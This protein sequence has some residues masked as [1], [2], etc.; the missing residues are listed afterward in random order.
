MCNKF[1]KIINYSNSLLNIRSV[2]NL[3]MDKRINFKTQIQILII[4]N[5]LE[6]KYLPKNKSNNL[7]QKKIHNLYLEITKTLIKPLCLDQL[8]QLL[9]LDRAM[10]FANLLCLAVLFKEVNLLINL[11]KIN[12]FQT[13]SHKKIVYSNLIHS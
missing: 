5:L 11:Y 6:I 9:Y 7:F 2:H 13:N 3:L 1:N 10:I 8:N 4:H 12:S